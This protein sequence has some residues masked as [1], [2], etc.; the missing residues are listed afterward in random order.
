MS[1]S[2]SETGEGGTERARRIY[3]ARAELV[4][5]QPDNMPLRQVPLRPDPLSAFA[6]AMGELREDLG[7]EASVVIDLMPVT[8]AW[9]R[10]RVRQAINHERHFAYGGGGR[11]ERIWSELREE[12]VGHHSPAG[13]LRRPRQ[14]VAGSIEGTEQRGQNRAM[15]TK[16]VGNEAGF[17]MQVLIRASSEIKGRPQEHVRALVD[18]FRIFD[19]ENYLKVRGRRVGFWYLGA[20]APWRRRDFDRRY[21]T[22]LF[23]PPAKV[24]VTA[25]EIAG[26]LKPPTVHCR[27][28][29][30]V[31]SGGLIPPAPRALPEFRHQPGVLPLG[32]VRNQDGERPVGVYLRDTY[33]SYMAGR[34][35]YGKT[36]TAI[37]QFIHLARSGEGCFFLDPH[38]DA[39][40]R[41]K[42]YLTDMA[43]RV[44]EINLACGTG[45]RRQ[46]SWNLF[47]MEGL[48]SEDVEAKT[49]TVLNSF[50]S[51]LGWGDR[52]SPRALALTTMAAQSLCELALVLPPE[53]AP[54]IF[55][56]STL[57]SNEVWRKAVIPHLSHTWQEF[58]SKRFTK[59]AT[60]SITPV[61][62]FIDRL[63]SST[64]VSALLGSS[65]STYDIRK[66]MDEGKIVL[67]CPAGVG[68]KDRLVANFLVYDLLHAAL[69][70]KDTP[71]QLRRPFY[72]FLDEV[73]TY[74][75]SGGNLAAL[76]EQSGKF[77]IRA[78]LL[79]QN[80]DRLTEAT[81]DAIT[82]NC[83]HLA[84]T[85]V[86]AK[87]ALS[88]AKEWGGAVDAKTIGRLEKYTY[89]VS[90]TLGGEVSRPFLVRGFEVS[91][92]WGEHRHPEAVEA[93]EETIDTS[94]GRRPVTETITHLDG[95]DAKIYE[96]LLGMAGERALPLDAPPELAG[97]SPRTLRAFPMTWRSPD[98]SSRV[99]WGIAPWGDAY[100]SPESTHHSAGIAGRSTDRAGGGGPLDDASP[101][102]VVRHHFAETRRDE[103][104][105]A[106]QRHRL[107]M[108]S[109]LQR[110]LSPTSHP[111][112]LRRVLG[113]LVDEDLVG[114]VRPRY[115]SEYVWFLTAEGLKAM[116][117]TMPAKSQRRY[118]VDPDRLAAQ[119]RSKLSHTLAVNEVGLAFVEAARRRPGDIFDYLSWSAE[120]AHELPRRRSVISDSVLTYVAAGAGRSG[121][122]LVLHRFV[123]LDRGTETSAR[124]SEK[125]QDYLA[126]YRFSQDPSPVGRGRTAHPPLWVERYAA[127]FPYLIV[128][129]DVRGGRH[130]GEQ[131][132][133]RTAAECRLDPRLATSEWP[134]LFVLLEDLHE[135]GPFEPVF[136]FH[137][138]KAM[139][140]PVN[141][142]GQGPATE[143]LSTSQPKR[144][145]A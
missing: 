3:V 6:H 80:P 48:T 41:I 120:V 61:T 125:L 110:L 97:A 1:A 22:G 131:R 96:H 28:V 105:R 134:I 43:D 136:W 21:E 42:P 106:L 19:G 109:Q 144:V 8:P 31:R 46:A 50:A 112:W 119:V 138:D 65:R 32:V 79:N 133:R 114:R 78:F 40:N 108:T 38:E 49:D 58:W 130:R 71:P 103:C 63:R 139:A 90:V 121:R 104:L 52:N 116:E 37:N 91:K 93:M 18:C 26:L 10:H 56:I 60:E 47:S 86:N 53:L 24:L 137:T 111:A 142:L 15:A 7:D 39:L 16:L 51:A 102:G 70:R 66:A 83:S 81:R 143:D 123:E 64:A 68:D 88:L 82:T 23:H 75:S 118:L 99:F 141:V 5:A 62:N 27:P 73:Q 12:V 57:L 11:L 89:L 29:N 94:L 100:L 107:L 59:L 132:I 135:Q 13:S 92:L 74:S 95:L 126:L 76:L 17:F 20:D 45:R 145:S 98:P 101:E 34:S 124:L 72:L 69:S 115:G 113:A 55:Q 9:R 4:L 2:T 129:F 84:T 128:V 30:V 44:V 14:P 36:E 87:A 54:T 117:S 140:T 122:D 77:G 67:A 33:F 127:A 25:P 35:R 85:L